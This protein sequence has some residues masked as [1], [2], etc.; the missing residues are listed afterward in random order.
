MSGYTHEWLAERLAANPQLRIASDSGPSRVPIPETATVV[1]AEPESP[2]KARKYRNKPTM[3]NGLTFASK[4]E[5]KRYQELDLMRQVGEIHNL[6]LQPKYA[7]IVEGIKICTY[8]ADFSYQVR[9]SGAT[10]VEDTKGVKTPVYRL[11]RKLMKAVYGIDI[12][13][14]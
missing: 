12:L 8:V 1:P 11:K 6:T 5:A 9:L 2:A 4:K 10:V 13:E 14:T 7:I 3:V